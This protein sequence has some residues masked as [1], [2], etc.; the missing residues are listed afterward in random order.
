MYD[1]LFIPNKMDYVRGYRRPDV[2][3]IL[4]AIV[5]GSDKVER[6][7]VYRSELF[8]IALNI[9]PYSPG[10][11]MIFPKR[12]ITDPREFNNGE[13]IDL[14]RLQSLCLNVLDSIYSPHGFNVGYNIGKAGGASIAHTHLHIVPRYKKELGFIDILG[15]TKIIVEDPNVSLERVR[16]AFARVRSISSDQ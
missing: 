12:H 5:E 4:C 9:Y 16:E 2:N 1:N 11:L 6:L 7:E 15:G 13:V 14:H 8:V 3:C 10:H